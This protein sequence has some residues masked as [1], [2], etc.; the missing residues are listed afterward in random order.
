MFYVVF[1]IY[2]YIG[3]QKTVGKVSSFVFILIGIQMLYQKL[4]FSNPSLKCRR[5]YNFQSLN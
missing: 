1:M 3:N 4:G 5:P 2:I